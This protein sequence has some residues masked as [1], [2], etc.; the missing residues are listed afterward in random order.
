MNA[1]QGFPFS[2]KLEDHS[3][4]AFARLTKRFVTVIP[5]GNNRA[6]IDTI[7]QGVY[8]VGAADRVAGAN[9]D[10]NHIVLVGHDAKVGDIIRLKT[11][12]NTIIEQDIAVRKVTANNIQFAGVLSDTITAADT[13]DIL[14]PIP[15]RFDSTGASLASVVTP[16]IKIL[17]G[18][19]SVFAEATVTKDTANDANTIPLPVEIVGAAGTTIN[20]TAGDINVQLSHTGAN[21]ESMQVGNGANLMA[22]NASL[23]AQV[24]DDDANTAIG[25]M[26]AKLPAALGQL[27]MVASMSVTIASDQSAININN[28]SGAVSLPTLAATST[29]QA[30]QQTSLGSIDTNTGNINGKLPGTLGQK[31]MIASLAVVIAS[32]QASIPITVSSLPLPALAATSTIQATQQTSLGNIDTKL[33]AS[34]GEKNTA[35]SLSVTLASDESLLALFPATIGQKNAAGSLAVTLDSD[36]Q[37]PAPI[38][39]VPSNKARND[40]TSVNVTTGAWVQLLAAV[41]VD[42]NSI[43]IFDSSGQTLEIGFGAG[44]AE[45]SKF[46]VFPGGNGRIP[47]FIPSGTRIAIQAISALADAGEISIN[48]YA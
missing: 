48:F 37:P 25:L 16:P 29:I 9:S 42:I 27:A 6:A 28:I 40:Y 43:E 34:V 22:V 13:F 17:R 36:Y 3:D 35:S 2:G 19:N 30:T 38:G 39:H 46:Y 7:A 8:L 26:S 15:Q 12:A 47:I 4:T 33:P 14:R 1:I 10:A 41:S 18:P 45:V 5:I 32:D 31:A 11:T 44:G 24:R 21:P 23:E 20:I